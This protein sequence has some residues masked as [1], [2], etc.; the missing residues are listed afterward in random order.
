MTPFERVKEYISTFD[1]PFAEHARGASEEELEEL[2]QRLDAPLPDIYVDFLRVL[3]KDTDWIS[4]DKIDFSIDAVLRYY[5]RHD[6]PTAYDYVRIGEDPKDPAFH[7]YI[8]VNPL[9]DTEQEVIRIPDCS[10]ETFAE[11]SVRFRAPLA[12]SLA[13]LICMPVFEM[14]EIYGAGRVP[15]SLTANVWR[16]GA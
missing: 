14:Y 10:K 11:V 8:E 3:G 2:E 1:P 9:P 4:I 15:A 7:P 6:W 12:G 13:E 5:R 16:T